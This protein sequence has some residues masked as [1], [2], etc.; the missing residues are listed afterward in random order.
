MVEAW[1]VPK[2]YDLQQKVG[3]EQFS[4]DITV[5]AT[6]LQGA[7]IISSLPLSQINISH[8]KVHSEIKLFFL[9]TDH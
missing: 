5:P 2:F 8:F 9:L 6:K 1:Q 4:H 7:A 3:L